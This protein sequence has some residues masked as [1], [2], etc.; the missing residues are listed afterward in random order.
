[1]SAGFDLA[2]PLELADAVVYMDHIV[3][4]L[5]LGKIAEE[6]GSANLAT[7]PLDRRCDVEKIRVAKKRK[8]G[9]RK[10][11][12][13]REG[14][15]D[16]QHRGGFVRAFGSEAGGGVFRFAEH[17]GH[18]IFAADVREAFDLSSACRRQKN[19]SAGSELGLHL[20]HTSNDIPVKT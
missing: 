19:C 5:Q 18:F 1:M 14:C 11:H 2:K 13:F 15:A 10:R 7:G 8:P 16:Q 6:A 9:V 3:A 20:S 4:R 12:A 17:I